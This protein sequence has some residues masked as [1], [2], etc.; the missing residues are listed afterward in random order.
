MAEVLNGGTPPQAPAPDSTRA[1]LFED[2]VRHLIEDRLDHVVTASPDHRNVEA[3]HFFDEETANYHAAYSAIDSRNGA[4]LIGISLVKP[5]A[6]FENWLG[7]TGKRNQVATRDYLYLS[8]QETFLHQ[9]DGLPHAGG[10]SVVIPNVDAYSPWTSDEEI[11]GRMHTLVDEI[12]ELR[13][14]KPVQATIITPR[15]LRRHVYF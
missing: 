14:K 13:E 9:T 1:E 11:T 4:Y 8:K 5:L 2:S 3:V 12:A 10:A 15:F 6:K 7:P